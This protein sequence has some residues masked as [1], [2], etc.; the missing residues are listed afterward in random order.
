MGNR[1]TWNSPFLPHNAEL[2][3]PHGSGRPQANL[4]DRPPSLS[5]AAASKSAHVIS[6]GT[7]FCQNRMNRMDRLPVPSTLSAARPLLAVHVHADRLAV[8]QDRLRCLDPSPPLRIAPDIVWL[9]RGFFTTLA[10]IAVSPFDTVYK[11]KTNGVLIAQ[12][13]PIIRLCA[14]P[15]P[16]QSPIYLPFIKGAKWRL[17]V[18]RRSPIC[19]PS[20]LVARYRPAALTAPLHRVAF[21]QMGAN[22]HRKGDDR[23]PM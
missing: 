14:T 8:F 5:V 16:P 19:R 17:D 9:L 11:R 2:S 22:G 3:P 12:S 18:A 6:L 20:E 21:C 10:R 15:P 1:R 23:H 13:H 4:F 7:L